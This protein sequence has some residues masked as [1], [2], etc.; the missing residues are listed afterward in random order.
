MAADE[1]ANVQSE[2]VLHLGDN[3]RGRARGGVRGSTS[4]EGDRLQIGTWPIV[5]PLLVRFCVGGAGDD[6]VQRVRSDVT[7]RPLGMREQTAG[8]SRRTRE[9]V[10][11]NDEL[12][13][14]ILRAE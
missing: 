1:L 12:V 3:R 11:P 14:T 4:H 8:V 5:F 2:G 10:I 6:E 13:I 7:P 9:V